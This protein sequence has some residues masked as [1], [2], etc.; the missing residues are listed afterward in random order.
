MMKNPIGWVEIPVAD[1][2]R[3]EAFYQK[4]FGFTLD[5]QPTKNGFTMSWFPM[6]MESYGSAATLIHG[7]GF[8]SSSEG[9]LI[10]FTAPEG[11]VEKALVKA[12]EQGIEVV[13]PKTDT[14]EHGFF[15]ILRDSEGNRFAIHSMSG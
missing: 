4:F 8:T 6:D 12:Q 14:G 11:S 1:L 2:D 3:A 5:R 9:T 10:Y 15:A 7:E 13:C